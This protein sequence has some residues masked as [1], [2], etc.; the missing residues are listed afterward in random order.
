MSASELLLSVDVA[1]VS[2]AVRKLLTADEATQVA[3]AK[4]LLTDD[5][6]TLA[7]GQG[8]CVSPQQSLYHL[9][10]LPFEWYRPDKPELCSVVLAQVPGILLA[11]L[12]GGELAHTHVRVTTTRR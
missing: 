4:A 6:F 1:T 9:Y 12:S 5:A 7:I 8:T 10:Q 11:W 3:Q 2:A